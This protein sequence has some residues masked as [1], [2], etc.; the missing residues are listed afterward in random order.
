MFGDQKIKLH[1]ASADTFLEID[2][3]LSK[4]VRSV[5]FFILS[6]IMAK[7]EPAQHNEHKFQWNWRFDDQNNVRWSKKISLIE[8]RYFFRKKIK[9]VQSGSS[10]PFFKFI[11][12]YG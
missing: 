4:M 6:P 10:S 3:N 2:K 11:P 5:H 8:R 1:W 9:L 12:N 7:V